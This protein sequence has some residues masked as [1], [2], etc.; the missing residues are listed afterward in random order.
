MVKSIREKIF[1]EMGPM[2]AIIGTHPEINA[3]IVCMLKTDTEVK[4][5]L[6]LPCYVLRREAWES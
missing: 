6:F 5:S 1:K 4:I 2:R 3:D